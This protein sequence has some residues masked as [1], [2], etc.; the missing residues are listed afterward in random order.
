MNCCINCFIDS[1]LK[2][3][4][5]SNSQFIGDCDFCSSTSTDIINCEQ[6]SSFFESLFDL[7]TPHSSVIAS[8][9]ID[10]SLLMYEHINTYWPYLFNHEMLDSKMIKFLVNSIAKGI[11]DY[12]EIIFSNPVELKRILS[13]GLDTE[14]LELQW[15]SFANEIKYNNRFFLNKKLDTDLLQ[16]VFERLGKTYTINEEFFRAR[17]S[18]ELLPIEKL[19]KPE[20]NLATGGRANPVGI[21]YLYLSNDLK[22]TLFETRISLHETIS[23]GKFIAIENINLISLT[24]VSKFGPFEI[25]DKGFS[26]EEFIGYRPYLQKLELELSKPVRKQDVHLDYLPTQFL[27]E[28]LKSLGFD[29]VEYKSA[30]NP[31]GSNLALFTDT[32]VKCVESKLYRINSLKYTWDEL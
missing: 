32:K 16:S 30:M 2:K 10:S 26:V 6:L 22:T 29:A 25:Q 28:F 11:D 4:I 13:E 1:S 31:D 21:P 24:N 9:K 18:D 8:L 27:C 14:N 12:D 23:V 3:I 19:G 15:D 20:A 5:K 7:Y 17:I